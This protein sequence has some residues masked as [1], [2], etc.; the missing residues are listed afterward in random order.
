MYGPT[1]TTTK[2]IRNTTTPT[3]AVRLWKN[4][5]AMVLNGV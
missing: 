5:F 3:I 2:M 1:M 4:A